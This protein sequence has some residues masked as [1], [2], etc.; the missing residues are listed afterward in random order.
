MTIRV[1]MLSVFM[2]GFSI[3][4]AILMS[5]WIVDEINEPSST[6]YECSGIKKALDECVVEVNNKCSALWSY[7]TTLEKEN[8]R[9]NKSLKECKR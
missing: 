6:A 9:L 7:A 5:D 8:A 2:L 3:T 4:S 1:W